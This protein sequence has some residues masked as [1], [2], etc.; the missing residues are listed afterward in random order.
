[1]KQNINLKLML[2]YR[3][4]G[5]N[6]KY[7]LSYCFSN[8]PVNC[9]PQYPPPAPLGGT[10]GDLKFL[11]SISSG[12][13]V[14]NPLLCN[15]DIVRDLHSKHL[16]RDFVLLIHKHHD[17]ASIRTMYPVVRTYRPFPTFNSARYRNVKCPTLG[18]T[19]STKTP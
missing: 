19:C 4:S 6:R 11:I 12:L 1:M 2:P 9:T 16:Q 10:V 3:R 7:L 17:E 18:P 15:R 14:S 8:A 13:L 5:F